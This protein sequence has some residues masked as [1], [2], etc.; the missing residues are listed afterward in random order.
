VK[1]WFLML[2]GRDQLAL[3][4]LALALALYLVLMVLVLPLERAR[5]QLAATNIATAAVLQRVDVMAAAIQAQREAGD[6]PAGS[7]NLSALLSGSA[8]SAGLRIS[9]LQPNS[10]G[11]VQLRFESVSFDALLRWLHGLEDTQGLLLEELS[12]S[13]TGSSGIV[14]ASLRIS[15]PL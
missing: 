11:G 10:R 3:M 13:Q 15:A 14:S 4:V 1:R 9:R 2:S 6:R 8:E 12:I 5:D 7:R